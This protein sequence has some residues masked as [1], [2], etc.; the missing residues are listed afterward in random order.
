VACKE[1]YPIDSLSKICPLTSLG[2][3]DKLR[4]YFGSEINML[5]NSRRKGILVRTASAVVLALAA[6]AFGAR[7]ASATVDYTSYSWIGDNIHIT[8]PNNVAGGAG[9]ITLQGVTGYSSSTI[10]AWCLDIYDFLQGSGKYTVLGDLSGPHNSPLIGGLMQEGNSYIAQAQAHSNT[11]T[12]NNVQYN[13]AD[14]SAATQVAIWSVEYGTFMS[15]LTST[16]NNFTHLVSFL[17]GNAALNVAY[18]T[19]NDADGGP[20]NQTLGTL[21]VPGPIL[22]GGL[23]G[24]ILAAS[25][26]LG[27]WR[28][29][30][31]AVAA[32]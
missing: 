1:P 17:E 20:M 26:V 31:S 32:A 22:G 13:T 15:D 18:L 16:P 3:L 10:L 24:L 14:I 6:T 11:L 30:R 19:L 29:R 27:W 21:P 5:S 28:R 8:N 12:I 7:S 23:P 9:Q 2:Y 25:G 4:P